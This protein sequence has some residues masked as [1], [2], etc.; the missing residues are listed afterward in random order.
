MNDRNDKDYKLLRKEKT[1]KDKD[2]K[3]WRK[4]KARKAKDCKHVRREK[5]LLSF[6]KRKHSKKRH[7]RL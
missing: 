3:L 6:R 4:E 2:C 7:E 5:T 1:R